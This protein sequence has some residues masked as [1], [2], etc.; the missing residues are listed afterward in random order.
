VPAACTAPRWRPNTALAAVFFA[1][2]GKN[3]LRPGFTSTLRSLGR[4]FLAPTALDRGG[5][6]GNHDE[7]AGPEGSVPVMGDAVVCGLLAAIREGDLN[8]LLVLAD[9]M[10]ERGDP[11]ADELRRLQERLYDLWL[12]APFSFRHY[13]IAGRLAQSLFPEHAEQWGE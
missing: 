12:F 4:V 10:E 3:F 7:V 9:V 13:G 8:A 11:R 5:S 6:A 1:G 2:F